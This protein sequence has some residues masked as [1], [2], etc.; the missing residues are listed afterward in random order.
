MVAASIEVDAKNTPSSP[1]SL[2]RS[3]GCAASAPLAHSTGRGE[4]AGGALRMS[5][6]YRLRPGLATSQNALRL[7]EMVGI[8]APPD[9]GAGG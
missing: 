3:W 5:F 6:D 7:M 9:H 8:A 4:E 2:S 1:A